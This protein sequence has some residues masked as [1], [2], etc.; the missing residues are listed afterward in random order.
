MAKVKK[1]D[2]HGALR[3]VKKKAT[4][5]EKTQPKNKRRKPYRGQGR[6]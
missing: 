6:V 4:R 5:R 1:A 2:E 3:Y